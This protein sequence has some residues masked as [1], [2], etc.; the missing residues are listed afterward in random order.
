MKNIARMDDIDSELTVA[1]RL[2]GSIQKKL[3]K[4][5][6]VMWLT[7]GILVLVVA[8]VIWTY[9]KWSRIMIFF[10]LFDEKINRKRGQLYKWIGM[11]KI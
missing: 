7:I 2:I 4:N 9:T 3:R 1:Q 11:N 8:F 10:S 6:M 5:K